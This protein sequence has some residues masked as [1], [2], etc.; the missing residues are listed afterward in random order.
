MSR[1]FCWRW[2]WIACNWAFILRASKEDVA[3][4]LFAF[5]VAF[6]F[7]GIVCDIR[8]LFQDAKESA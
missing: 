4:S 1:T 5:S 2:A 7:A 6:A 3:F 8:H